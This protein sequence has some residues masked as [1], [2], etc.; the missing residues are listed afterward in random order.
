[1]WTRAE[2]KERAK[3]AF[4]RNY[5]AAVIVALVLT[6]I[7]GEIRELILLIKKRISKSVWNRMRKIQRK[8]LLKMQYL[9]QPDPER[10]E[11]WHLL[12]YQELFF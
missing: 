11:N 7:A 6:L 3:A 8:Q 12:W 5:K 9:W 10:W 2:L 1:M 4:K